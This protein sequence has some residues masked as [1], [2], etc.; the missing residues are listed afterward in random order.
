[1]S[2]KI[3]ID[4]ENINYF[5][6]LAYE[7][8]FANGKLPNDSEIINHCL[9]ELRLFEELGGQSVT[10]YIKENYPDVFGKFKKENL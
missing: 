8:D 4:K 6:N 3:K 10:D 1:M 2:L 5:N 9:Q 7:L